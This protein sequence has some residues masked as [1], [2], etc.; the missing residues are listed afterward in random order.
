MSNISKSDVIVYSTTGSLVNF[1]LSG[2][3]ISLGDNEEGLYVIRLT[4]EGGTVVTQRVIV[5]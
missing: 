5:H 3:V 1:D 4:L 2:N